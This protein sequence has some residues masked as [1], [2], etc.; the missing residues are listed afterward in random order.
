MFDI[1]NLSIYLSGAFGGICVLVLV[2]SLLIGYAYSERMLCWHA[3]TLAAA[4]SAHIFA[5]SNAQLSVSLWGVQLALAAQTLRVAAGSSG[6]AKRPAM[7]LRIMTLG[8]AL[9]AASELLTQTQLG[10]VLVPWIAATAF[11]FVRVW[12]QSKPWI[13]WLA[14]GQM[15]LLMQS[16]IQLSVPPDQE[17]TGAHLA[18]LAALAT[19]AITTYLGMVWFSRL[20][21]ENALRV[22]ARERTDPLTGLATP[23]VFFDRVDGAIIRSRTIGY[24]CALLLIRVENIE[25]IVAERALDNNEAVVLA[26]SRAIASS[27]RSQDSAARLSGNR[28]G[29]LA[30]GLAQAETRQLATKILARGLRASEWGLQGSELQFQIVIVEISQTQSQCAT[31]L[32]QLEDALGRITAATGSTRIRHIGQAKI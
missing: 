24:G 25:Q 32:L 29:V 9:L 21:A 18:G 3:A 30:E 6:A 14:M 16:L 22:E 27:L 17:G 19:F 5:Q 8:F 13:F 12:N 10:I 15:A 26:A 1:A 28:F 4:V 7:A 31:I 2:L 20:R 23:A 11:Y